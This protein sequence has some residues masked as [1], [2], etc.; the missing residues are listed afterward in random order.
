MFMYTS[1]LDKFKIYYKKYPVSSI[2]LILNTIMLFVV[3]FTGGF[4]LGNL[5]K[6][7][8]LLPSKINQD[9]EYF[10]LFTSMFLH[11]SIIHFLANSYFLYQLGSSLETMLGKL[12]YS[13]L[14]LLSGLG[15]SLLVWLLGA[16][17]T[18]TIGASGALFGV[19]GALLLLT[20][21]K[22]SWFN[23]YSIRSIRSLV[24][25]NLIF[26]LL[27]PNISVLGHLGGFITGFAIMRLLLYKNMDH[28]M[29]YKKKTYQD[30]NIIDHDDISDDDIYI[31]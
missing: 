27:M 2:L 5:I 14:Y 26:T 15:G 9:Q 31:H 20:Y 6:W 24:F 23:P 10:R 16:E 7:G 8:G 19:L 17:N 21:V 25:I 11:G 1:L 29:F 18:V 12:K 22:S 13:I 4:T 28:P 3:I 30:P